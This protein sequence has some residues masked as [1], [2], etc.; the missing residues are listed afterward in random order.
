[1]ARIRSVFCLTA[2]L[3]TVSL[4]FAGDKADDRLEGWL[5]VTP[6]DLAIK[7]VPGIGNANANAIQL[8]FSYYKDDNLKFE[9][10]YHRIKILREAGLDPGKK[11]ADPEI[12][13]PP[14]CSLKDLSARTIH[15][16]GSIVD[17]SG[18]PLEKTIFKSRGVKFI[19]RTFTFPDVTVG[20][21]IEYRYTINLPERYVEART[22]WPMQGDLYTVKARYR[23]R[24]YQGVVITPTEWTSL[25]PHSR[26]AYAYLNQVDAN[27]PE[28][29]N[30]NLMELEVHDVPPFEAEEYMPPEL[31]YKPVLIFYYGGRE[32]A[33]PDKYWQDI[34]KLWS[35]WIEKFIG[36]YK[37]VREAA[38]QAIGSETDPETKLRKLYA[39]A[40]QVRNLS[41]ERE[42]TQE[43]EK[44]ENLKRAG[45]SAEVLNHG[46]GSS[47][48][49]NMLFVALARAAGFEAYALGASD[50]DELSFTKE[51]LFPEQFYAPQTLIKM[52]GK[53]LMLSPGTP[54]CP[55]GLLRWKNTSVPALKFSKAGAE[56]VTT[57]GPQS[58]ALHRT[59]NVALAADGG[60]KGEVT[61]ELGGED[62][63]ERR[64]DVLDTDDAG[65]RKS[66]E[67]MIKAWLPDGAMVKLQ[68]AE[69]WTSSEEPLI[70]RFTVDIPNYASL[71]GKR[72]MTPAFFFPTLQKNMFIHDYRKYPIVFSYPFTETD[73]VTIK[74]PEGYAMEAPPYRRKSSLKYAG[75]EVSSSLDGNQLTTKRT[76]RFDGLRFDPDQYSELKSFFNIVQAGDAG[77]AVLQ[78]QETANAQQ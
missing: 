25:V 60:L 61:V 5:P 73:Q 64:L 43:E 74:L 72:L 8:Y 29:K 34:G 56:F 3:A 22:I 14:G 65:R 30:Q 24:P 57:P 16:D 10:A 76:L 77:Q 1:M 19:A 50:R 13:I 78:R 42:R 32:L 66:L 18:K 48:G 40:Q 37:E 58:A 23:F 36:N 70:G 27:I 4:C 67:D 46:Y 21:I 7:T 17:F 47:W 62:A 53:D 11:Y 35:D 71:A 9:F 33:S 49:I 44:K 52:D 20:S 38:T 51:L 15:P 59:A 68:T 69:G 12:E 63:L 28:K 75:Y 45:T 6:A 2:I 26:V 41:Y 55:F 31:D 54:F 39:R